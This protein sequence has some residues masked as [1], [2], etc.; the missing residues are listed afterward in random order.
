[1]TLT[2]VHIKKP[3]DEAVKLLAAKLIEKWNKKN[4]NIK[5]GETVGEKSSTFKK[6]K[7]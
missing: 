5:D 2:I 1:M 7:P 3:T 4:L 6:L